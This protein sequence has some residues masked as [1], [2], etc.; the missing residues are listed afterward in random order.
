MSEYLNLENEEKAGMKTDKE[1]ND[2]TDEGIDINPTV[3]EVH[4]D[5][6]IDIE[7]KITFLKP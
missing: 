1:L 7:E 5:V 3:F 2:A 6:D 4:K